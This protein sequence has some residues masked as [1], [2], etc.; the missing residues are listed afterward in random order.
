MDIFPGADIVGVNC[1]FEPDICLAV[2]QKMKDA[3]E[4]EGLKRHLVMQPVAYHTPELTFDRIG[5][6][7]LPEFPFGMIKY[8]LIHCPVKK[9]RSPFHLRGLHPVPEGGGRYVMVVVSG[10]QFRE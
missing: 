5:L 2:M 3:L 6:S 9:T 7:G 1:C 10:V 8:H 4:K